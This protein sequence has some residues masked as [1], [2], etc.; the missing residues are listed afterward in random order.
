M[1][2]T[3]RFTGE[4]SWERRQD[5][6]LVARGTEHDNVLLEAG[7]AVEVAADVA[8]LAV[9][10]RLLPSAALI[11]RLEELVNEEAFDGYEEEADP[12]DTGHTVGDATWGWLWCVERDSRQPGRWS[13]VPLN[14]QRDAQDVI[15]LSAWQS[16]SMTG[17]VMSSACRVL[18]GVIMI[19]ARDDIDGLRRLSIYYSEDLERHARETVRDFFEY[20]TPC[21]MCEELGWEISATVDSVRVPG[22]NRYTWNTLWRPCSDHTTC[23]FDFAGSHLR[24]A[25]DGW[26]E[27]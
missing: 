25:D 13:L 23:E 20:D 12:I 11:D 24:W 19:F 18:D 1:A 7:E 22:L 6:V 21:P 15:S 27:V 3:V 14:F 5:G 16:A 8:L 9:L 4:G 17:I 10:G 26:L 2:G